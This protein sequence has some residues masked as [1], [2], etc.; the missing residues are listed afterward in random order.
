M[1]NSKKI[2]KNNSSKE[3]YIENKEKE[4]KPILITK[5]VIEDCLSTSLG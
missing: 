1:D 4:S 5:D 2:N 3:T